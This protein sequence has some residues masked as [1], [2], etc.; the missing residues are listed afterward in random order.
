MVVN[1]MKKE[2]QKVLSKVEAIRKSKDRKK[3]FDNLLPLCYELYCL[4]KRLD[5]KDHTFKKI[6]MDTIKI[7][8]AERI[9]IVVLSDEYQKY[10][11]KIEEI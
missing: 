8:T 10:K 5:D 4:K 9:A 7:K 6:F 11:N 1:N 2:I 3:E